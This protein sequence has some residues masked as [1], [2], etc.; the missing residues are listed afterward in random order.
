MKQY[1]IVVFYS[2]DDECWV[3]DVPDLQYCSAF[4]NSPEEALR[5][6]QVA[7]TSWLEIANEDGLTIPKPT[8][9]PAH[10]SVAS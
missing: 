8:Y 2:E 6:V 1:A 10:L 4:G 3:A 5:E 7:M 9:R